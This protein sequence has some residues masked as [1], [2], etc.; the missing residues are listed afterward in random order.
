MN[1]GLV[2]IVV[3]SYHVLLDLQQWQVRCRRRALMACLLARKGFLPSST[4]TL[5]APG[6]F[7][8]RFVLKQAFVL[9][10]HTALYKTARDGSILR[11]VNIVSWAPLPGKTYKKRPALSTCEPSTTK[12]NCLFVILCLCA[13]FWLFDWMH[14][15]FCWLTWPKHAHTHTHLWKTTCHIVKCYSLHW[16]ESYPQHNKHQHCQEQVSSWWVSK[17][18]TTILMPMAHNGF[19]EVKV[20]KNFTGWWSSSASEIVHRRLAW[21][22]SN[23]LGCLD[24]FMFGSRRRVSWRTY[25]FLKRSILKVCSCHILIHCAINERNTIPSWR[26]LVITIALPFLTCLTTFLFV[27]CVFFFCGSLDPSTRHM[28]NNSCDIS[29]KLVVEMQ[30]YMSLSDPPRPVFTISN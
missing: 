17:L 30:N 3:P 27:C 9:F 6:P 25:H 22:A 29:P 10:L 21:R 18:F 28:M 20:C 2:V 24:P 5:M 23:A 16:Q 7:L 14:L 4:T 26:T 15:F 8:L 12:A 1:E 19:N 13:L 11:I